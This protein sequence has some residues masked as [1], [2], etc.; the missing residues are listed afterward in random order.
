MS[1][2]HWPSDYITGMITPVGWTTDA[3][4]TGMITVNTNSPRSC[5]RSGQPPGL[6]GNTAAAAATDPAG[7]KTGGRNPCPGPRRVRG[8][9][10]CAACPE[11]GRTRAAPSEMT[12]YEG[13]TQPA[14]RLAWR[15]RV[16]RMRTARAPRWT[17]CCDCCCLITASRAQGLCS[18]WPAPSALVS[19][20]HAECCIG[21]LDPS[22]KGRCRHSPAWVPRCPCHSSQ[23]ASG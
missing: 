6:L 11:V 3:H 13:N 2:V 17:C 10:P 1:R 16:R 8:T 21:L 14:H 9:R 18:A 20:G 22:D 15:A 23:Y 19:G 4:I 5:R 12:A 7:S